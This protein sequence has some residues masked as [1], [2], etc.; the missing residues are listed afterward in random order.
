MQETAP[1]VAGP[2][3]AL[4]GTAGL[5]S[6]NAA[7]A[8]RAPA[9]PTRRPSMAEPDALREAAAA[10]EAAGCSNG[11]PKRGAAELA[12]EIEGRTEAGA[13][14]A[15]KKADRLASAGLTAV[16]GRVSQ[17]GRWLLPA[18]PV[19]A[20]WAAGPQVGGGGSEAEAAERRARAAAA[21][22]GRT[23]HEARGVTGRA[24]RE[25][26]LMTPPRA[27]GAAHASPTSPVGPALDFASFVQT[28]EPPDRPPL[29]MQPEGKRSVSD[30]KGVRAIA[31]ALIA[32]FEAQLPRLQ[33]VGHLRAVSTAAAA[34]RPP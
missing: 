19:H 11:E 5:V 32:A 17:A 22:V 2:F 1:G 24:P 16:P 25:A 21:R 14:L 29:Q 7:L 26:A 8:H 6:W 15:R 23:A 10:R 18:A 33:G 12:A 27:S 4:L 28:G 9:G 31:E 13:E 3:L 20:A 34:R 30:D